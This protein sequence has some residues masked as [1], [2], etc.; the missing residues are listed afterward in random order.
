MP[1]VTTVFRGGAHNLGFL[2]WTATPSCRVLIEESV[3]DN[4]IRLDIKKIAGNVKGCLEVYL[5]ESMLA[6]DVVRVVVNRDRVV[7][8]KAVPNLGVMV[9]SLAL[10]Q[11]PE[12]IFIDKVDVDL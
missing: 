3:Q 9:K 4:E 10:F 8:K 1:T 12:R 2:D 7:S 5:P 11:D 6:Y